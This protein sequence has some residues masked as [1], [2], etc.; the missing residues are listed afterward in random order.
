MVCNL[1]TPKLVQN[2]EIKQIESNYIFRNNKLCRKRTLW[3]SVLQEQIGSRR[4]KVISNI[5][6]NTYLIVK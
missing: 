1:C 5:Y 6:P 4:I 2:A 3:Y